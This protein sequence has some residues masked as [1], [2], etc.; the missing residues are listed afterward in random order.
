MRIRKTTA[1]QDRYWLLR[2]LQQGDD[3]QTMIF[4]KLQGYMRV[5][6]LQSTR[7]TSEP[8][9]PIEGAMIRRV[10][11]KPGSGKARG[12]D[13]WGLAE[14]AMLPDAWLDALGRMMGR[15]ETKR[16]VAGG[17]ASCYLLH[18]TEAQT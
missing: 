12:G 7:R 5:D 9:E 2:S 14:L 10:L 3:E 1:R 13:G 18:D 16:R 17:V 8:L 15:L 4:D 11:E 6:T